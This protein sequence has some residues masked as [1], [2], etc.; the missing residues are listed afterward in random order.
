MTWVRL[1]DGFCEHEKIVGLSD[2]AFRLHVSALCHCGRLLTDGRV[3]SSHLRVLAGLL[4]MR[5]IHKVVDELIAARLWATNDDGSHRINDYL[6]YNPSSVR[7]KEERDRK[8]RN[9]Q[10]YRDRYRQRDRGVTASPTPT[11]TYKEQPQTLVPR[12]VT[13]NENVVELVQRVNDSFGGVS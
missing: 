3:T 1:D 4:S 10:S 9:Q 5:N 12:D 11:P 13:S 8:A 6:D 2:R 7:V